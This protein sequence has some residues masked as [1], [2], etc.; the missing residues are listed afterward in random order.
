MNS[1]WVCNSAIL[2]LPKPWLRNKGNSP[3]SSAAILQTT[4]FKEILNFPKILTG[5]QGL[6]RSTL[7]EVAIEL[8]H[9]WVWPRGWC[10]Y[11]VFY[12]KLEKWT[13]SQLLLF[14]DSSKIKNIAPDIL[15]LQLILLFHS[16]FLLNATKIEVVFVWLKSIL[17]Y[18]KDGAYIYMNI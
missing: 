3:V 7:P 10:H 4:S 2:D 16:S 15:L 18:K 5:S 9:C 1:T 8:N 11:P 12:W 6:S 13:N 17:Y 14:V